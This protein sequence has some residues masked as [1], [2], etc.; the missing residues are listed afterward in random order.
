MGPPDREQRKRVVHLI[1]HADLEGN[2][3][4]GIQA[5]LESVCRERTQRDSEKSRETADRKEEPIHSRILRFP[6]Q[7]AAN[8]ATW[9]GDVTCIPRDQVHVYMHARLTSGF[10]YVYANVVSIG[11]MLALDQALRLA[12]EAKDI[13]L[14]VCRHVE[15]A[16]DVAL[17]NGQNV[18]AT[19]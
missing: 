19:Q 12:Q 8:A 13:G 16:R 1:T 5:T 7:H 15:E 2:E 4:V 10:S 9:V 14:F 17:W 3:Q 6:C 11:R 18:T